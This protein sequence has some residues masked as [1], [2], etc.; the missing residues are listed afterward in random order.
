MSRDD[1]T[2]K[3]FKVPIQ[4]PIE[5]MIQTRNAGSKPARTTNAA[6]GNMS[7]REAFPCQKASILIKYTDMIVNVFDAKNRLDCSVSNPG[8]VFLLAT[9]RQV[10]LDNRQLLKDGLEDEAKH[11]FSTTFEVYFPL[12]PSNLDI[13]SEANV[14]YGDNAAVF[15]NAYFNLLEL[16]KVIQDERVSDLTGSNV[17]VS[18]DYLN[19]VIEKELEKLEK[20]SASITSEPN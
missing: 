1:S 20:I 10:L 12:E 19:V 2:R 4:T 16:W 11:I 7:V 9:L 8:F 5:D 14:F 3:S 6:N 15:S 18:A 17:E 13:L